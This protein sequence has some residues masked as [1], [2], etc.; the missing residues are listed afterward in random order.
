MAQDFR[1]GESI[2]REKPSYLEVIFAPEIADSNLIL[3]WRSASPEQKTSIRKRSLKG[4]GELNV[5]KFYDN[6]CAHCVV[7]W[8]GLTP[9]EFELLHLL[10]D[11][12]APARLQDTLSSAGLDEVPYSSTAARDMIRESQPFKDRVD[13]LQRRSI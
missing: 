6:I 13:E 10:E 7:G 12:E 8:E 9:A 2:R 3:H 1:L 5:L 4:N 11:P